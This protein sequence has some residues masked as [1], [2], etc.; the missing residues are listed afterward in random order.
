MFW[1]LVAFYGNDNILFQQERQGALSK[2]VFPSINTDSIQI[3]LKKV[4]R[5]FVRFQACRNVCSVKSDY[6]KVS[7]S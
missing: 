7:F 2:A 5:W 6:N 3:R 1:K 4:N